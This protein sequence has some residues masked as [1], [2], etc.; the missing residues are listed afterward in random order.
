MIDIASMYCSFVIK[1]I[2]DYVKELHVKI[3]SRNI[4]DILSRGLYKEYLEK[5]ENLLFTSYKRLEIII[6]EEIDFN[7]EI[8]AKIKSMDQDNN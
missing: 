2:E 1:P 3:C 7:N 4:F 6:Q 8:Q 5:A